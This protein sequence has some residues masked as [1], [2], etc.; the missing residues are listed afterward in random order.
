MADVIK[1]PEFETSSTTFVIPYEPRTF[2]PEPQVA[3]ANIAP[4]RPTAGQGFPLGAG[5]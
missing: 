5:R 3:A 1:E 2:A 4:I